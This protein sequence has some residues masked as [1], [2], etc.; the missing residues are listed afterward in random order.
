MENK[1]IDLV[2]FS[3]TQKPKSAFCAPGNQITGAMIQ[4]SRT[5][6]S[7]LEIS[8]ETAYFFLFE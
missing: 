2:R 5:Q 8:G 4:A 3:V 1:A 7:G 6:T